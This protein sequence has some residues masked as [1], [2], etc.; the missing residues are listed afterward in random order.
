MVINTNKNEI[1][2]NINEI[3]YEFLFENLLEA[4][5]YQELVYDG[6]GKPINYIVRDINDQYVKIVNQKKENVINRKI[7]E[8]LSLEQAPFLEQANEVA[9][10]Q[11]SISF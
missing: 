2:N 7:T 3:N 4:I 8:I 9:L 5:A 11:K 1:R 10:T 6:N